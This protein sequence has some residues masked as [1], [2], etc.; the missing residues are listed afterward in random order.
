[1]R[2]KSRGGSA[3]SSG[4]ADRMRS[5]RK[6]LTSSRSRQHA[7]R[8]QLWPPRKPIGST[9]RTE[10]TGAPESAKP[11]TP[12]APARARSA[13]SRTRTRSS[14]PAW[15][16]PI[17]KSATSPSS[18]PQPWPDS[19][20]SMRKSPGSATSRQR[21]RDPPSPDSPDR[22]KR[23][24]GHADHDP[25][26]SMMSITFGALFVATPQATSIASVP[27]R[28]VRSQ[29]R[30][31]PTSA[32]RRWH[33]WRPTRRDPASPRRR[34][35]D[36]QPYPPARHATAQD[37]RAMLTHTPPWGRKPCPH[38]GHCHVAGRR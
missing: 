31:S 4:S 32:P 28:Q 17:Q 5:I 2:S 25:G 29:S 23:S 19:R 15:R 21:T 22:R 10:A 35:P 8:Y 33:G 36:D 12:S 26:R 3:S 14:K 6:V 30:H 20:R 27:T 1:L 34:R 24:S 11:A 37:H 9:S 7:T 16:K 38:E 13:D 18:E